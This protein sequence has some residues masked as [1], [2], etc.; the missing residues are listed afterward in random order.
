[1]SLEENLSRKKVSRN[2]YN[3]DLSDEE[4]LSRRYEKK[5][6]KQFKNLKNAKND[7][8]KKTKFSVKE[9]IERK[10]CIIYKGEYQ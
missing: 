5:Y 6:R 4:I 10:I 1:M 3:W 7:T 9:I 2:Q 8:K